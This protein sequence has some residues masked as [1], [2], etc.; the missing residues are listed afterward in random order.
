VYSRS[1]IELV[2]TLSDAALTYWHIFSSNTARVRQGLLHHCVPGQ[3]RPDSTGALAHT[4]KL[5]K[6]FAARIDIDNPIRMEPSAIPSGTNP[7][8]WRKGGPT[9]ELLIGLRKNEVMSVVPWA[10]DSDKWRENCASKPPRLA[11]PFG[12]S[13]RR[14]NRKGA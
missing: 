11:A 3:N 14:G 1:A 10:G 7:L 6:A 4:G 9:H 5:R 12:R 8:V 13:R 2:R